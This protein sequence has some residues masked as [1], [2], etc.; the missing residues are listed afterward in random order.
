MIDDPAHQAI[1]ATI[2][3]EW[4]RILAALTKTLGDL[5]LAEDSLQDAVVSALHHWHKNGLPNSPAAW[6]IQTARRKA[7]D[8]IRRDKNFAAKE[9]E[10]A[11]LMEMDAAD[12]ANDLVQGERMPTDMIPDKRLEM[13]FT[14]CHPAIEEKSRLALTL[15]TI[16]G[17]ST[18]EIARAFLDRTEAM[19]A[20][21]T[22]SR[23]KI[24][25]AR[26]PYEIPDSDAL[27]ERLN[28]V[29]T[30]IYLIF[31]EGYS[32]TSGDH[33]IRQDLCSEALRLAA[34][35]HAL[36]P[37]EAEAAGLHALLL[38]S[39]ARRAAR[40]GEDGAIIPLEEHDRRRWDREKIAMGTATLKT[41]LAMGRIGP[42]Q[43]QAAISAC[44]S[45]AQTWQETDWHEITALYG[46]LYQVRP[47]GVVALNQAYAISHSQSPQAALERLGQ[48]QDELAE[49]QPYHAARAD[50]LKRTGEITAAMSAYEMAISLTSNR[51][52]KAWLEKMK[53]AL[54]SH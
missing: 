16:G 29:L 37:D 35:V 3:A 30:V 52:E 28:S 49:Y 17:L 11:H 33:L 8:R 38:L 25:A 7:I 10:I 48:L 43:L 39:D 6:L 42:Y 50:L 26:I 53:R 47:T 5:Q 44:H 14:C 24:A 20:R 23:K 31:N 18:E 9:N 4:G 51:T 1:D 36:L 15:R 2:R 27:P 54:E 46:L 19:A 13:I 12:Q 40:L 21:L 45:E 34:M 41:A 32:A 22:R